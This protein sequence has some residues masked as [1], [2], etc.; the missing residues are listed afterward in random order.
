MLDYQQFSQITRSWTSKPGGEDLASKLNGLWPSWIMLVA[1]LGALCILIAVLTYFFYKPVNK[2]IQKRKEFIQNNIDQSIDVKENVF[3][4]ENEA[5]INLRKSQETANELIAKAKIDG[6]NIKNQ[7]IEHGKNESNKLI[8]E[9][10]DAIEHKKRTLEK[11]SYDEIV[12]IA[13]EISKKI[14]KSKITEAETKK[15]LDEYLGSKK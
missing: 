6:E 2:M 11:E 4:L 15:Y 8:E 10:K 3:K 1:T 7:Y 12:S 9:A 13:M 14:V 5:K